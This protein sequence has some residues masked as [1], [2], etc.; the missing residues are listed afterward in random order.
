MMRSLYSGVSGLK[1]HQTRM[2][3]IG[4]NIANVNTVGFKASRVVFQDIY[5]QMA[6]PSAAPVAGGIVGGVNAIQIGLGVK[7]AAIDILHT[8]A[9]T[10]ITNADLDLAIEGD[11]FFSIRMADGSKQ[12]TRTGNM[13]IDNE[14]NLVTANG[15]YVLGL[16]A[17]EYVVQYMVNPV[18]GEI[19]KGQ[20]TLALNAAGDDYMDVNDPLVGV[21]PVLDPAADPTVLIP[22]YKKVVDADPL[23]FHPVTPPAAGTLDVSLN[24]NGI[25]DEV[26]LTMLN[27]TG[28]TGISIDE[29]GVIRGLN[30]EG[31]PETI[32]VIALANFTNV[33]GLEKKG[34]SLY[35]ETANTGDVVFS[36]SQTNGV[37]KVN[38]GGLEMSNVDLANEFTDMIIT[39]RGFQANSRVITTS[40]TMLEELV[41][42][43]R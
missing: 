30:S 29:T 10:Q 23:A 28:Y 26:N 25:I 13:Y 12:Y 1:N 27:L 17:K 9:A 37:G 14:G 5:S 3:V 40:D 34:N 33:A 7:M 41:N 19:V 11:G 24:R 35:V 15:G 16:Q 43:K 38:P 22:I 39:Q 32:A 21:P 8:S 6:K 2:D 18:T 42:L 36:R 20:E 31:E 4:N